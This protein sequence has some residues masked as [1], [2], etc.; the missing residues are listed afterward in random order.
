MLQVYWK[1]AASKV[2]TEDHGISPEDLKESEP[3]IRA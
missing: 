3:L 2:V 1:N